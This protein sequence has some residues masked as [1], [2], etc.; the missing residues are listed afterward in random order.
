MPQPSK[1]KYVVHNDKKA[2][3]IT[4]NALQA[5]KEASKLMIPGYGE[6]K[7]SGFIPRRNEDYADG[8]AYPEIHVLQ[9][10]LGMGKPQPTAGTSSTALVSSSNIRT[11]STDIVKSKTASLEDMTGK[12]S[13]IVL[14]HKELLLRPDGEEEQ[15]T[16]NETAKALGK[17]I[18]KKLDATRV[19]KHG[20][21]DG[22]DS[23]GPKSE[24]IR[25][26]PQVTKEGGPQQRIIR[27]VEAAVDPLEPPKF[28][29]LKKPPPV[30]EAPVP[31][32]HSPQRKLT[33]EDQMNWDIPKSISN[34][35]NPMGYTIALDKRLAADGRGLREN[36]INDRFAQFSE[37]LLIAE[38]EARTSVEERARMRQKVADRQKQ[39][40]NDMLRAA[41]EEARKGI[42]PKNLLSTASSS[43]SSLQDPTDVKNVEPAL[44]ETKS[45]ISSSPSREERQRNR[46]SDNDSNSSSSSGSGST[47]DNSSS[48]DSGSDSG[49]SDDSNS[50]SDKRS[51]SGR[52][53]ERHSSRHRKERSRSRSAERS[54]RHRKR[55]RSRDRRRDNKESHEEYKKRKERDMIRREK[56][57]E[58]ERDMRLQAS[59][60]RTKMAREAERDISEKIA[61]GIPVSAA[62]KMVNNSNN[63]NSDSLFDSRLFNKSEGISSGFGGD[64]EEYNEF[65][66]ALFSS[67][68]ASKQ[69]RPKEQDEDK[70]GDAESQIRALKGSAAPSS[71]SSSSGR[72]R[73]APVQFEADSSDPSA[74]KKEVNDFLNSILNKQ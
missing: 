61:L 48:S 63:N 52:S 60:K 44:R 56:R 39:M 3:S 50:E 38:E 49:S 29:N 74:T 40:E 64:E 22:D 1:D 65:T 73:M 43:L 47:S 16:A 37:S 9:Y 62:T 32:M 45:Q 42:I 23:G 19:I 11:A 21:S 27:V 35:T 67:S 69:Y 14:H 28:R 59:G 6:R 51:T 46:K 54:R 55:S 20:N 4:D 41:A 25:Y 36:V 71:S 26:T 5:A 72:S 33:I 12:N 34:W 58:I 68:Q 7:Q 17:I 15:K 30:N 53:R 8:G 2:Y 66:N 13:L 70:F 31:V 57:R 10:P 24:Y 18:E